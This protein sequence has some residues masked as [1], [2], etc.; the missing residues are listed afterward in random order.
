MTHHRRLRAK[1]RNDLKELEAHYRSHGCNA[2]ASREAEVHYLDFDNALKIWVEM[3]VEA[4]E[5]SEEAAEALRHGWLE[6]SGFAPAVKTFLPP[7]LGAVTPARV[8]ADLKRGGTF[9][10]RIVSRGGTDYIV[11]RG[12]H[13]LRR[14]IT[15]T[16]Y[17]LDNTR[18][19][20]MGFGRAGAKM[21]ARGNVLISVFVCGGINGARW[22]VEHDYTWRNFVADMT[23]DLGVAVLSAA[24][25]LAAGLFFATIGAVTVGTVVLVAAI[26]VVVGFG[27]G[28][29]ADHLKL[30]DKLLRVL[31]TSK[32]GYDKGKWDGS[33]I[34][35]EHQAVRLP[36]EV[37]RIRLDRL[38]EALTGH[39]SW[40]M[41]RDRNSPY[42]SGRR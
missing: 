29:L 19:V 40:G 22:M 34:Y 38:I 12:N 15:G 9:H 24:A 25:M 42:G 11:F 13:R 33:P 37:E 23:V 1:Y 6:G 7:A 36:G 31:E 4:G 21:A 32:V 5:V 30:S 27:L 16:R 26:G 10:A 20:K 41:G 39:R 28:I 3:K 17:R 14:L 18:V 2:R 35:Y 8:V